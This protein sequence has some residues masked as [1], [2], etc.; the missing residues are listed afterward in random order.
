MASVCISDC[1]N[2]ACIVPAARPTYVN[3]QRWSEEEKLSTERRR[4][5]PRA[6]DGIYRRQMYLRSYTFSREDTVVPD[7]TT[8]NCLGKIRQRGRPAQIRGGRRRSRCFASVKAA[9]TQASSG[10]L[11]SMFRRLLCRVVKVTVA[12]GRKFVTPC[13]RFIGISPTNGATNMKFGL[14]TVVVGILGVGVGLP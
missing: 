13:R 6:A 1:V 9:A 11:L 14:L 3:L 2:D 5:R 7:S 4:P 10:A 12:R 8:Q